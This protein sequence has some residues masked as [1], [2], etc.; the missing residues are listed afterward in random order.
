ML[1][2]ICIGGVSPGFGE[3]QGEKWFGRQHAK[4]ALLVVLTLDAG[5]IVN[6]PGAL[7]GPSFPAITRSNHQ[8]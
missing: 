5:G 2:C 4:K 3:R 8:D 6:G 7:H 1:V